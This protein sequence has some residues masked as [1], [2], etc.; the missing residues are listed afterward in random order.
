LPNAQPQAAS[1]KRHARSKSLSAYI[2]TS[3]GGKGVTKEAV[4]TQSKADAPELTAEVARESTDTSTGAADTPTKAD[5]Q[6]KTIASS[7]PVDLR[8]ALRD[9]AAKTSTPLRDVK[10][11]EPTEPPI[12]LPRHLD[13]RSKSAR[14]TGRTIVKARIQH[15]AAP[16]VVL[17]NAPSST[18][19]VPQKTDAGK[20]SNAS[21]AVIKSAP[22]RSSAEPSK[23]INAAGIPT[24][25]PESVNSE[26]VERIVGQ[27]SLI[28]FV[29]EG[30]S[31]L[32]GANDDV[33]ITASESTVREDSHT[34]GLT[35]I[36]RVTVNVLPTEGELPPDHASAKFDQQGQ[37][38][39]RMGASRH[40]MMYEFNWEASA[41]ATR[42]VYFEDVN[43]ERYGYSHGLLLEPLFSAGH[44]F[45]RVPFIPYMRG[46]DPPL[47]PVYA[48]GYGR[49]GSYFPYHLHRP[50]LSLRGAVQE[51]AWAVGLVYILP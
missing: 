3:T 44:F 6:P 5:E 16:S 30:P 25:I 11:E 12:P 29:A 42:P 50:P 15:V 33:H 28:T 37:V 41:L 46:A 48:L 27:P 14:E 43:L 39:Q 10:T 49:P 40:W 38:V 9:D 36:D 51:A 1:V 7:A 17:R 24:L 8:N 4:A 34:D 47:Q 32:E 21:V 23:V 22:E 13:A 20:K 26:L 31:A 45:L 35:E 19:A 18:Q 2:K